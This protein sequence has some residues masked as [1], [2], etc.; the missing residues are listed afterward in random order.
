MNAHAHSTLPDNC[1][2]IG[3]GQTGFSCAKFLV[4][5]GIDVAVM[6]TREIPPSLAA[7]QQNY[8]E[9][10]IKTGGLDEQWLQQADMIVLSP[11]VDP[12]IPELE[13]ARDAGV[14]VVG[15]IELFARYANAPIVAITGSNGKSTVTT[16]LAEMVKAAGQ[17]AQVGGNLGTPAL[18]LITEPAPDFYIIE[19]SSFQLET[20]KSLNA[21]TAVILNVSPDHLDRY[22]S[23]Q[24]YQRAKAR[25]YHGDGVMVLNRDDKVV[26]DLAQ[27]DRHQIG[28][29]LHVSSGVD[30]G[31]ITQNGQQWIAEG[32]Q[33]LMPVTELKI[34][35][36]HNVANV[37]AALAL[38]SAMALPIAAMLT[39]LQQYS[40][41]PH[42][43][44]FVTERR[45]VR[46]FNDSKATNVGACI[47]AI[48]GMAGNCQIVLIA[49][50]MAKGQD[51]RTLTASLSNH[52]RAV[53]LIGQDAAI[54]A[55][56]IPANVQQVQAN[57]MTDAVHKADVMSQTGDIVLLSPAC[58]SFDMFSGYAERGDVFEQAVMGLTV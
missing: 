21:F 40:G 26:N 4:Q 31:V 36:Q 27:P 15:D 39:A 2:I 42:R 38:G 19:L 17:I 12:R 51:F 45:G 11:G 16:L 58:A 3:L 25:I 22:D 43:S 5:Q 46:W 34:M 20:V 24:D 49:G 53:I 50:G 33:A 7:L 28:F 44:H 9:V 48:E 29:S 47:A 35:G 14:E 56:E 30:F 52:V 54:L 18:D 1:L 23:V 41:L 55:K 32:N 6:D 10:V 37:L 13:A 8:P 57:D